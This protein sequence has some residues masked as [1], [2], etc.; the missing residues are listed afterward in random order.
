MITPTSGKET[1]YYTPR[2]VTQVDHTVHFDMVIFT[3]LIR[4]ETLRLDLVLRQLVRDESQSRL[5]EDRRRRQID[6]LWRRARILVSSSLRPS[7]VSRHVICGCLEPLDRLVRR[8]PESHD[9]LS[10]TVLDSKLPEH[11]NIG[12]RLGPV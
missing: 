6:L 7:N 9:A 1:S 11:L 2:P 5:F 3:V 8:S 12:Y 10:V 4:P